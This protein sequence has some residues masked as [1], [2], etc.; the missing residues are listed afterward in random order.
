M[1]FIWTVILTV[2]IKKEGEVIYLWIHSE[3]LSQSRFKKR[4]QLFAFEFIRSFLVDSESSK[5]LSEK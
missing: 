5:H 3:F 1:S 2:Q 4:E